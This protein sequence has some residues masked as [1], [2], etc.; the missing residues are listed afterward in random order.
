VQNSWDYQ[1]IKLVLNWKC[2]RQGAH[3]M[4]EKSNRSTVDHGHGRAALS[5]ELMLPG[6]SG[7]GSSPRRLQNGEGSEVILTTGSRRLRLVE[8]WPA[9]RTNNSG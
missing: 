3:S 1:N 9:M 7:H 5:P 8:T 4:D 2:Y 6:G